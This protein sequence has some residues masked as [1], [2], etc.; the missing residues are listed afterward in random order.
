MTPL[1]RFAR[2]AFTVGAVGMITAASPAVFHT[3]LVKSA[4]AANDT[5]SAAP[6]QLILWFSEKI[7]LKVS[8]V[9]LTGAGG[10]VIPLGALAHVGAA[11]SSVSVPVTGALA[12]G[13]YS[14][15]WRTA[16]DDGHPVTGTFKFVVRAHP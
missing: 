5:L 14:V 7:E 16:S 4:P 12:A 13:S 1:Q 6:K 11:D 3:K 2:A 8:S 15:M 9:K 10:K